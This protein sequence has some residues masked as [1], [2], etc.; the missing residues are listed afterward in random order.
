M[1][2]E[3]YTKTSIG[4]DV[5][6]QTAKIAN[7][8][9]IF[10]SKNAIVNEISEKFNIFHKILSLSVLFTTNRFYISPPF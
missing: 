6:H 8:F 3:E 5:I 10:Q 1:G 4:F 7:F 9:C 2:L